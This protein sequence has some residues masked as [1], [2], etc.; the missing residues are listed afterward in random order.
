MKKLGY[1]FLILCMVV[2]GSTVAYG[3]YDVYSAGPLNSFQIDFFIANSGPS[4]I[5]QITYTLQGDFVIDAVQSQ[6]GP[7][8]GTAAY[9]ETANVNKNVFGFNFTSFDVGDSF[10]FNWDPDKVGD[11]SYGAFI[12]DLVGTQVALVTGTGTLNG[13]MVIDGTQNHLVTV[14]NQVP[15]PLTLMLLGLG[16]VGVAGLRRRM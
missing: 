2:T 13:T 14:F 12:S 11:P 3:S 10:S 4:T 9:F 1:F 15:E 8:G 7:A 5:S 16:L 6:S